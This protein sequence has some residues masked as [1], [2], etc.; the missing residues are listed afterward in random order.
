MRDFIY[1]GGAVPGQGKPCSK[2]SLSDHRL[3]FD[4][5]KLVEF[6]LDILRLMLESEV[7]HVRTEFL[8][9]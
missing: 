4:G 2:T 3:V 6:V 8:V 1:L 9:I 7:I 5:G